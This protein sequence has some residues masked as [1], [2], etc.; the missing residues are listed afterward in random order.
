MSFFIGLQDWITVISMI[1]AFIGILLSLYLS[2][3]SEPIHTK[4]KVVY[5]QGDDQA[6]II[7]INTGNSSFLIHALGIKM[8]QS[9]Y[10]VPDI[11]LSKRYRLPVYDQNNK[12]I[13]TNKAKYKMVSEP[14]DLVTIKISGF[15]LDEL[16]TQES[17]LF[18]VTNSKLR[19]LNKKRMFSPH[20]QAQRT[21]VSPDV[22]KQLIRIEKEDVKYYV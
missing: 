17:R 12:V 14:G 6:K 3:R 13:M 9:Y 2:L 16:I 20:K 1:I 5:F 4:V 10:V 8:G 18:I 19:F 7:V 11:T 15:H 21:T 22:L